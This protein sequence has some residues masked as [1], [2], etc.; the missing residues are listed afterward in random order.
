[1]WFG[2]QVENYAEA[3]DALKEQVRSM[4]ID[5][6]SKPKD[7]IILID[8]LERLGVAY[9]FEQD[10]EE[11]IAQIFTFHEGQ[12]DEDHDLFTTA[13]QFRLFRQHGYDAPC[14]MFFI[15]FQFQFQYKCSL[16]FHF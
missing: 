3:V 8:K 1:M 7:K 13:L 5:K 12:K 2:L 9:H 14:S 6:N 4:V 15:L 11:Q 16:N 10:I